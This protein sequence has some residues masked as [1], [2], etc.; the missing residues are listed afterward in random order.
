M[1]MSYSQDDALFESF[2]A[3]GAIEDEP[4]PKSKHTALSRGLL[5]DNGKTLMSLTPLKEAWILDDIVLSGR[6]DIG[7]I[8]D[9]MI[10]DNPDLYNSDLKVLGEMGLTKE[11]KQSFFDLLLY[12]NKPKGKP[13]IDKGR[14]AEKYLE[15]ICHYDLLK[16][17]NGLKILKFIQDIDP[18]DV[19]PRVF[20]QFKSLVGRVLKEFE[21]DIHIVKPFEVPTDWPVVPMIDFHLSTPQMISYWAVNKQDVHYC[22]G[23]KWEN[24]NGD[25]VADDIIRRKNKFSWNIHDVY[26]DPLSKG[27]TAYMKNRIGSDL[28]DTYSII[29]DKLAGHGITLH[30]ASKDKDSGVKNL[31]SMLRGPNGLPTLYIFDTCDRFLYEVNRWV[32]D[33]EGKPIK[34]NDHS[35]EN[36]YRYSLV[37]NKYEEHVINPLPARLRT[38]TG[39]WMGA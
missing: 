35:M 28:K 31:Q 3:Q 9:L 24:I 10:T 26:I 15:K 14:G 12:E 20:G 37:G 4:P 34:E 1:I 23:E 6:R 22:I 32:F 16:L 17:M 5:L 18:S 2:R 7:V 11:Q 25:E 33:D 8:K 21:P 38:G 13:V 27:D 39:S 36:A 30:V 19:P 29:E